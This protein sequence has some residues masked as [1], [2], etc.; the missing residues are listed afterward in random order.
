M[1]AFNSKKKFKIGI[2]GT[3]GIAHSH[4]NAYKS[5]PNVEVVALADI[6]PGRAKAFA[7]KFE[8]TNAR[9]YND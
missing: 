2:I 1:I 3:G 5:F 9:I 6:V 8:L 4:M 7:E